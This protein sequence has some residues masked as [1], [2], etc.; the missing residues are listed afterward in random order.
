MSQEK[1]LEQLADPIPILQHEMRPACLIGEL[2]AGIE[3]D[4]MPP[5]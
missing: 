5:T 3:P 4:S 2:E 1:N